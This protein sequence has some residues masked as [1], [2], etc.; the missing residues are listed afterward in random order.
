MSV[1]YAIVTEQEYGKGM[2]RLEPQIFET[3]RGSLQ[4]LHELDEFFVGIATHLHD[5]DQIRRGLAMR[6][7]S[8]ALGPEF[9]RPL[10]SLRHWLRCLRQ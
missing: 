5:I 6:A 3:A 1:L 10:F 2:H 8:V 4:S 7:E 9:E